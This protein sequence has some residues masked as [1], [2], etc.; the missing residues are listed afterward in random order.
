MG[1]EFKR[2]DYMDSMPRWQIVDDTESGQDAIK[3]RDAGQAY[4]PFYGTRPTDSNGDIKSESYRRQANLTQQEQDRYSNLLKR[5]I[6]YNYISR[7]VS[8]LTGLAT[9]EPVVVEADA[10]L[11]YIEGNLNGAGLGLEQHM[12]RTTKLVIKHG[13]AGLLVDFP[14]S[15]GQVSQADVNSGKARAYT[16]SYNAGQIIN[17]REEQIGSETKLVLVVLQEVKTV[18][19]EDGFETEEEDQYRVLQ[20]IDGAYVQSVM[21]DKGEITEQFEPRES[22]GGRFDHIPFYFVGST[23]NDSEID[24]TIIYDMAVINIGHY[25]N[26]ADYENSCW[27]CGQPI[28]W[29]SG[30]EEAHME[31]MGGA[32]ILGAGTL[33]PVP[34]GEKFGIEQAGENTMAFEAMGHKQE[35]MIA[36]GVKAVSSASSFNTA[37]EAAISNT[38]ETS[39]LQGVMD[40]VESAY[41][42]ALE[43][44]ALFMG[45]TA[46][47]ENP[48]DLSV[49]NADPAMLAQVVQSWSLGLTSSVDAR[50]YQRKVGVLERSDEDID[51]DIEL[52]PNKDLALDE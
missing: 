47:V 21:N 11:E 50:A 41:N 37:T 25:V 7:T 3:R 36:L 43:D 48:T 1:V 9:S 19:S 14:A 30:L 49:L 46:T 17:W 16:A 29:M 22:G 34:P 23:N 2:K 32:P 5:A 6:F 42:S 24:E 12:K 15:N 20:L 28:P 4:L 35:Q 27:L 10:N 31:L 33:V 26:S 44:M 45:G 39:F 38:S 13:R 40:N 51:A 18:V 52:E 8:G